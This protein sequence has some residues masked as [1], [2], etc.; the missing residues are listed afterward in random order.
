MH[1]SGSNCSCSDE[2]GV[3]LLGRRE[4]AIGFERV[5]LVVDPDE[6]DPLIRLSG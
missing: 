6:D 5:M 2:A 3:M 1:R 4:Q